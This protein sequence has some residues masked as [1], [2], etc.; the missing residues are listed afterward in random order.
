MKRIPGCENM[1]E[2]AVQKWITF[3][4]HQEFIDQ[5]VDNVVLG[6][7]NKDDYA[8]G[9]PQTTLSS[10]LSIQTLDHHIGLLKLILEYS[11]NVQYFVITVLYY[12]LKIGRWK[13]PFSRAH[14][15]LLTNVT[16]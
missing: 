11:R 2:N 16:N 9:E 10:V 7:V 1:D 15:I 13:P 14:W 4:E 6:T 3:G 5:E 12:T 8:D